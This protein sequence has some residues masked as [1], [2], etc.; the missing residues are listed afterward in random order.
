[1]SL[2]EKFSRIVRLRPEESRSFRFLFILS[3]ITGI[4]LSFYFVAVNSFLIKNT[5]VSNLPYAYIISGLGGV[6]LIK[7]YQSRQR[8]VGIIRSY[9]E[10]LCIFSIV[11]LFVYLAYDKFGTQSNYAV[12]LAYFGFLFNMPF[13]IIFAL[14]FSAICA[15][16][17]NLAQSKR[18]LALI[19]TGEIIASI[20]G[21]L[22]APLISKLLGSSNYLLPAAAICILPA[23]FPIYKLIREGKEKLNHLSTAK[24]ELKKLNIAFFLSQRFYL[25]IALASIFSVAAIYFVDYAC[26]IT[27]RFMASYSGLEIAVIVGVFFS[28]VKTGELIFSF[29]SGH[30]LSSK[31]IKFAL[32]LLPLLLVGCFVFATFGGAT[33]KSNPIFILCFIFLAKFVERV[34]R[35][36]ITTPATKVL[37]QV[38]GSDRLRIEATVE[39]LLNQIATVVSGLLLLLISALISKADTQYFLTIISGICLLL[40][41][42]WSFLSLKL[43]ENYKK[44]IWSYL[45][46]IKSSAES[47]RDV[48]PV[49]RPSLTKST[50]SDL[51]SLTLEKALKARA[52]S[53]LTSAI[54]ELALYSPAVFHHVS[55]KNESQLTSKLS[56]TYYTNPNFFYRLTVIRYFQ[57]STAILSLAL[58]K[59][60]W[61]ISD[62]TLKYELILTFN[63]FGEKPEE[64]D[65]F[66]F[67]ELCQQFSD[68]LIYAM[69]AQNDLRLIEDV[70]LQFNLKEQTNLLVKILFELL[71]VVY[72]PMAIKVIY[73]IIAN[74]D[75]EDIE[76]KL[77]AIELLDN[78]LNEVLKDKLTPIFEPAHFE[79]KIGNLQKFVPVEPMSPQE[80]LKNLLLKDFK[81]VNP[82]LKECCLKVYYQL[83]KDEQLLSAFKVSRIKNLQQQAEKLAK[84]GRLIPSVDEVLLSRIENKYLL[85]RMQYTYLFNEGIVVQQNQVNK[86][87]RKLV[88]TYFIPVDIDGSSLLFDTYALALFLETSYSGA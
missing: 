47:I 38:T 15:R 34:I 41:F 48:V 59:E 66:Y 80:A 8:K 23:F 11:S 58:F 49:S 12:Y 78:T 61:E 60:F 63:K 39:G 81:L 20:I 55:A 27:V 82:Q 75:E 6:V 42:M 36:A 29:M 21:Y 24:G 1:M 31:G 79:Q 45:T 71:G 54:S 43:Y 51:F 57:N 72:E 50:D 56:S 62:L 22:F 5:S 18:L 30:I 7:V 26:L 13:T 16:L 3:L 67:E 88:H 74:E 85:T 17:Y 32:L 68:E 33:F 37:Y 53:K 64:S 86:G 4:A 76:S 69:S 2:K 84:N 35:K 77:F 25:L 10:F 70:D 28:C 65:Y 73:D 40:F 52:E 14:S 19:G 87:N 46:E 9:Q 83:S 44:K